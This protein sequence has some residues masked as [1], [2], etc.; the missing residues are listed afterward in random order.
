VRVVVQRVSSAEVEVDG[1]VVGSI[2]KG[3]LVLVG[4]G[5]DDIYK[6]AAAAARKLAAL[7]IFSDDAGKMNLSVQDSGGSALVVSQ[8]TLLGE[9]SRGNRP[10]FVGAAA[11]EI[12]EP[13]VEALVRELKLAGVPVAQGRFGAHMRVSLTNDGPV[14]LVMDF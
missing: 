5:P 7:R 9:T 12:A 13:L 6:T 14:T 3:L 10:S 11:P 1:E 2:R 4:V 8:F